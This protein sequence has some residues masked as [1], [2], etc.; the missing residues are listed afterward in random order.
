M[1]TASSKSCSVNSTPPGDNCVKTVQIADELNNQRQ[2][3]FMIFAKRAISFV[4][5][6]AVLALV[7]AGSAQTAFAACSPNAQ[8]LIDNLKGAWRGSGTVK[9]IG[10][11]EERMSCRINYAIS[12]PRVSQ[13]ISCAGTDYKFDAEADIACN[14]SN[15]T[16]TWSEKVA[17]NTGRV[18]GNITGDRL[19]IE[20]DGPNF[21]GRFS[22][23]VANASKHSLTITQFDPGA[24]RH[25]PVATVSLSR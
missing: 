8:A 14:D 5:G 7:A 13:K 1:L 4:C 12:G 11:A 2:G 18:K 19:N 15:V 24:G 3:R 10:G 20:V 16:G 22:V 25:V 23:R 9:P 21:Q 17:N 6:A